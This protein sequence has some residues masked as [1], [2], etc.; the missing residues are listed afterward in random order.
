MPIMEQKQRAQRVSV[1]DDRRL[2]R[3]HSRLWRMLVLAYRRWGEASLGLMAAAI[4]FYALICFMPLGMFMVWVLGWA[5]GKQT[6]VVARLRDALAAISPQTAQDLT[7]RITDALASPDL[8]L[9]GV[10]GVL[11][12][13]WA[14]HRLFE[15][16]E[17]AL[18][19]VWHGRLV[20]GF[21][22]R[23]L[24]AFLMLV[25]AACL[26]GGYM[27]VISGIASM[28]AHLIITDPKLGAVMSSIWRPLVR[29][30]A[31][32]LVFVAFL[33]IYRFIPGQRIPLKVAVLGAAVATGLWHAVSALFSHFIGRSQAYFSLYGSMTS[34]V[35]FGLWAYASG[36]ILLASA[37]LSAAYFDVFGPEGVRRETGEEA[38][39]G[40]A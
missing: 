40:Q 25:A 20:R 7:D 6:F 11:A 1:N 9:T 30:V 19:R 13:A 2:L 21:F 10:L 28:R 34:V 26:L 37:A 4:G 22:M 32:G 39:D 12:L 38:D 14:S 5:W 27:L 3:L 29:A 24:L 15:A 8:P 31:G 16:L 35:L 36:I 17:G 18:T 23:K 33:L